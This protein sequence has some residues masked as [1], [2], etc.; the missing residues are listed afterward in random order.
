MASSSIYSYR[1]LHKPNKRDCS[2]WDVLESG[3]GP[4]ARLAVSILLPLLVGNGGMQEYQRLTRGY[5]QLR[6]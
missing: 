3:T 4:T 2:E 6:I 1:E 5:D